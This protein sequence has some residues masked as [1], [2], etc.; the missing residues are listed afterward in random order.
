[1]VD[2][3]EERWVK[4]RQEVVAT[5]VVWVVWCGRGGARGGRQLEDRTV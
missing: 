5:V 3:G 2:W 1:M 4:K